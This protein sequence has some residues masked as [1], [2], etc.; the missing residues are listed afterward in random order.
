MQ[1]LKFIHCADLHL[2]SPFLGL[3]RNRPELA[4]KLA[5]APFDTFHAIVSLAIVEKVDFLVI[6]GDLFDRSRPTLA[7]RLRFVTELQHL[8]ERK[9]PV[10]IAAGNHD[11]CPDAWS[12][13]LALPENV[14]VFS[15]ETVDFFP[16][17]RQGEVIARLGGISHDRPRLGENLAR[18]FGEF[19][20]PGFR[21]GVLH[22]E[23]GSDG[24]YA[25]V[26]LE[27]L[28]RLPVDYWALGHVHNYAVLRASAPTIV[29]P[30]CPQGRAVN[31]PGP[32][33]CV[34]VGVD[35]FGHVVP[36]FRE[37]ETIRIETITLSNLADVSDFE[38]LFARLR[39]AL[40]E[41][42]GVKQLLLRLRLRGAAALNRELREQD[43]AEL[44]DIFQSRLEQFHP[45]C[46]LEE[47]RIETRGPYDPADF[48]GRDELSGEV[49]AALD[50]LRKEGVFE[51]EG[52]LFRPY[53]VTFSPEEYDEIRHAAEE[54]LL[55]CLTC[56][57]EFDR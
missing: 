26:T 14:K 1:P 42:E 5:A 18:R 12:G 36:E 11:P 15:T 8:A 47:L 16:V 49:A 2:G 10:F 44:S 29:Y 39:E 54:R 22:A 21:I 31:E 45:G 28:A 4:E 52:R 7:G 51:E 24:C 3:A 57:L 13:S 17:E 30:G 35:A 6:A 9:I 40:S 32:R 20:A 23:V 27:E 43:P 37:L 53:G 19:P 46:F 38:R 25:P 34:L 48:A 56:N 33:G 50:E 41:F 55:D